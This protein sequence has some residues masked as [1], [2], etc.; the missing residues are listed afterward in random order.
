MAV[1]PSRR[2]EVEREWPGSRRP[3]ESPP[4]L[5]LL[6]PGWPQFA[7]GQ[8]GRG[9]TL[10]GSFATAIGV[11]VLAWGTWLG[12]A[13]IAFAYVVHVTSASD[14]IRQ[15]SFPVVARRMALPVVAGGWRCCCT[16]RRCWS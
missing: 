13:L 11:A 9:G 14:A 7:W 4:G 8:A 6:V 5:R 3:I 16:S 10:F 1:A 15:A 2:A 12:W